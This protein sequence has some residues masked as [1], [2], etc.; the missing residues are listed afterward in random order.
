[1]SIA[2]DCLMGCAVF[3]ADDG[4]VAYD[5]LDARWL[6]PNVKRLLIRAAHVT[7][8]Y[9]P[10]QFVIVRPTTESERIPLTIV[11]SDRARGT[12][13]LI[14]QV[15]GAT[16]RALCALEVGS[17]R[18]ADVVG[19]L[20]RPTEVPHGV[21]H[22]V[23]V[24]GGVGTAVVFPQARAARDAG[25][26]RLS[27]IIGGRSREHVILEPELSEICDVVFPCTDDGT[28]GFRG[29]VTER[30]KAFARE[31]AAPIGLVLCAG[32]L[33]M[34]RGVAAVTLP[35]GIRTIA[36]LNP[37]MVDGTGMCGGCRVHVGGKTKFACVD[38]PEFDAH[39]VDFDELAGRLRTYCEFERRAMERPA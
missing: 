5:L 36:S 32:P 12:I 14:V 31:T 20:G 17:A 10:G 38:G 29:M 9:R 16:T 22:V 28:Y 13:L 19:P 8:N 24:G 34:M 11:E 26:G 21:D 25:C 18:V 37:I 3:V 15:V 23:L 27:A 7:R 6:S 39:E 33:P 35:L 30:I 2:A 4:Y 1:M